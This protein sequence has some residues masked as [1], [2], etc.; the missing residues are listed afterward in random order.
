MVNMKDI[1]ERVGVSRASVSFV[2]NKTNRKDGSISEA[3]R[4]RILDVARELG[5]H[6]NEIA[7]S[8]VTGKSRT[9]GFLT[10][11]P[12]EG[13]VAMMLT[14]AVDEAM[15][16]HYFVSVLHLR[17]QHDVD[18]DTLER[19]LEM[20]LSGALVMYS[21]GDAFK[22]FRRDMSAYGASVILLDDNEQQAYGVHLLTDYEMGMSQ[23]V[24]HLKD[25][26][27]HRITYLSGFP[28]YD[29]TKSWEAR[30]Q[31]FIAAMVKHELPVTGQS[32]VPVANFSDFRIDDVERN[33]SSL[34]SDTNRP[35]ALVCMTDKTALI[36][37]RV[38]RAHGLSVPQD[39][40]VVGLANLS[41]AETSDPPLTTIAQPFYEMGRQG[42]RCLIEKIESGSYSLDT[43]IPQPKLLPTELIIRQSTCRIKT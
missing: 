36:A 15:A 1:A 39:V 12:S 6:R 35:T 41:L 18:T 27:H 29:A 11:V 42:I 20:R 30:E 28:Q 22:Q 40:S 24:R 13:N 4:S 17:N 19:C 2:L 26:G 31:A 16:S 43:D 8:V 34:F 21:C 33:V 14:G 3:T 23:A 32:V 10:A 7:R 37:L 5:Y 25:L 38:I 9:I